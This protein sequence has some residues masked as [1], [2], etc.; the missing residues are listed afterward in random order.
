LHAVTIAARNYLAMARVLARSFAEANPGNQFTI[1]VVDAA[2]GEVKPGECYHIATP[3]DLPLERAEFLRMAMIYDVT[4]LST[5]L[6][7]WALQMLLDGGADVAVYLDPDIVVFDS[8][9]EVEILSREHGIV[10]TPHTVEPMLRDGLRPTEA[11]I[12]GAGVFNLGFIAVASAARDML[13]WWQE[14]LRRDS[15]IAP[16]Q[17]L[18]VD[19]RWIDLVPGYFDHAIVRDP[20]YNVAYWNLDRRQLTRDGDRILVNGHPLRFFHFSGYTV[21]RPWVLSKYVIDNPRVVFSEHP[22]VR[23]LCDDY[24]NLITSAEVIADVS[25]IYRF[26]ALDD[27]TEIVPGLRSVYANA[28]AAAERKGDGYP[29]LPFSGNDSEIVSWLRESVHRDSGINRF[30]YGVWGSRPDLHTAFPDPLGT[31]ESQFVNWAWHAK[32]TDPHIS[33]SL[34]PDR[35]APERPPTISTSTPGVNLAGYF[36]AE[37]GVGQMGRL[38]VDGVRTLGLPFSTVTNRQTLSRQNAYFEEI[39]SAVRYPITIAA[40]N[41]DQFPTW[42][43]EVGQAMLAGRYTIGMWAWEVEEFPAYPEAM[44]MVDE[45]WTLSRFSQAAIAATTDKPVYV[46]PLPNPDPPPHRVLDRESIGL[47]DGSYFLFAFDYLSI[48]ERKNPLGLVEAF[49]FAFEEG[50]GPTLVIKSING[51]Q[52][53]ADRERLRM[54]CSQRR[55]ILLI[56]EYLD[57]ET[58]GSLMGEASA[59]VSLHRSEGYGLTISEAMARSRPVIA[60]GYSGNLDFMTADN[61]LLVPFTRVPVPQGAGPYPTTTEWAEPDIQ[62]AGDHM[63]WVFENSEE[64]QLFGDRARADACAHHDIALTASFIG[65]RVSAILAHRA[66]TPPTARELNV[67]PTASAEIDSLRRRLQAPPNL[68]T[69]SRLPKVARGV[70]RAIY[71]ALAHHDEQMTLRLNAIADEIERLDGQSRVRQ[72]RDVDSLRRELNEHQNAVAEGRAGADYSRRAVQRQGSR[73][74][75]LE[76][77]VNA[78]GGELEAQVNAV[79]VQV[80]GSKAHL[81]ALDAQVTA[82]AEDVGG[83]LGDLNSDVAR[84]SQEQVARPYTSDEVGLRLRRPDGHTVLGYEASSAP[85]TTDYASFEDLYRGSEKFIT[86]RLSPYLPLLAKHSPV[87]DIGCGRGELL[88]LLRDHEVEASGVDLDSSMLERCMEK[89]LKV[90]LGDGIEVLR[91]RAAGSLGGVTSVQVIE[92][93]PPEQVRQLFEAAY[94]ALRPGGVLMAET[95]NPHSP[96]AL[97][98][99]WLDLTHI[100]PLYPESL[101]FLARECG[102]ESGEIL[103]PNGSGDLDDDL[104]TCG[105]YALIARKAVASGAPPEATATGHGRRSRS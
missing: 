59:Y 37:L 10:L 31:H 35:V 47:P 32:D 100:R 71:R 102:F 78:V 28:L 101:L 23:Q 15:V 73:L 2:P 63:R 49:S 87:L 84:L 20:G 64:A 99:F 4:E 88:T 36:M 45:V 21:E 19:Q 12:M 38:L 96:A 42:G 92:H 81:T 1:L 90:Q 82:L 98:T 76:A 91:G 54:A 94:R 79:G 56:E 66:T 44:S 48:F 11:D 7:P 22:I 61:S 3:A 41:A 5:S 25:E 24:R 105:E 77:Q 104:R 57:A 18:F 69:P 29:P 33:E 30:L 86:D 93:I 75:E 83:A 97:K 60:T 72:Q 80:E 17:M 62:A 39:S 70:R 103:F 14:R 53:R 46:I 52:N 74:A 27:G 89:D 58:L 67:Q 55:D 85:I 8:L 95:V 65:E 43:R 34:L 68:A 6:K 9:E 26:D 16:H 40:V 51:D 50:S 13:A